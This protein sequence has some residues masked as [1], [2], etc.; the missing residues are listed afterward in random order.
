MCRQGYVDV[1]FKKQLGHWIF[2]FT[3]VCW[4]H[5][6]FE[7]MSSDSLPNECEVLFVPYL[8]VLKELKQAAVAATCQI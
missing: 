4:L 1:G 7:K 5:I 2:R 6:V 3:K 8:K